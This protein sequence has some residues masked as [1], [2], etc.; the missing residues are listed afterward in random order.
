MTAA[1]RMQHAATITAWALS[2]SAL[3][4]GCA[5]GTIYDP[6][7]RATDVTR[8]R[9]AVTMDRAAI[10]VVS[11]VDGSMVAMDARADTGVDTGVRV[12]T[13][14]G[15]RCEPACGAN[16]YC[17]ATG[18]QC[19]PGFERM[20]SVCVAG[21]NAT[22]PATHTE[23]EV[24]RRWREGHVENAAVKYTPGPTMC[25]PGS[26]PRDAVDD[27]LVRIN[28]FRWMVGLGP[29]SDQDGAN[30]TAQSCAVLE[31]R[32]G[33]PGPGNPDPHHPAMSV[34]CYS[35]QGAAGAGSSNI[36]WGTGSA[37]DAIDNFM[38]DNGNE[39]T[40]GHR[41]WIMNPPLGP[42]GVG[43]Y[44]DAMCLGVFGMSGGG[45]A[46]DFHAYPPPGP[47]PDAIAN[48]YWS[49]T[50]HRASPTSM[51]TVTMTRVPDGATATL[52]RLNL[53]GGYGGGTTIGW[54]VESPRLSAGETWRVSLS[55][56]RNAMGVEAPLEYT[57]RVASCP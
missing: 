8:A 2:I 49:F 43:F 25:D 6:E 14:V 34:A 39:S 36:S 47:I 35:P 40:L 10:D 3:A 13:G 19:A 11:V 4:S 45:A 24:C 18:C 1:N 7:G 29:V 23:A 20:G 26:M 17:A 42:V 21:S 46:L 44:S 27:A 32:A 54:R 51:T 41:R 28:M 57:V 5:P 52:R 12:D 50:G 37:A 38:I 33:W 15:P 31:S 55:N 53:A 56:V 30:A 16:A 48:G 9:D 22:D